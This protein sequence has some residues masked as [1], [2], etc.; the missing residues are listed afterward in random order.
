MFIS[1]TGN[2]VRLPIQAVVEEKKQMQMQALSNAVAGSWQSSHAAAV[3]DG[4]DDN[5]RGL[6]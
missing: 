4:D 3:T 1:K 5:G 2:C 6:Q